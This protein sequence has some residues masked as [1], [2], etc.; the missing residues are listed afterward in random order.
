LTNE[1]VIK[2]A[3]NK[4]V[5][6]IKLW[7]TDIL[8]FAKSFTITINELENALNEGMGFDGSSIQGFARIDESDMIAMPDTST[9]AILPYRPKDSAVVARMFCDIHEPNGMHYKGDPRYVLK[10]NL[11]VAEDMGFDTFYVGPGAGVFLL[12]I[13]QRTR[14]P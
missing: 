14:N 5:K 7:F 8:G 10:R 12:Q 6:F 9:F 11:K 3:H 13:R 2:L 4:K 1:Q